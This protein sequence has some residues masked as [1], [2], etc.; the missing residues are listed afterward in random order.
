MSDKRR[1]RSSSL[2]RG[3]VPTPPIQRGRSHSFSSLESL[4]FGQSRREDTVR[5]HTP[6][7]L[8]DHRKFKIQGWSRSESLD[9]TGAKQL[10]SAFYDLSNY[11]KAHKKALER[12]LVA[13]AG[14]VDRTKH[15]LAAYRGHIQGAT[16]TPQ[17]M[18]EHLNQGRRSE[19]A[20]RWSGRFDRESQS[21]LLFRDGEQ[22]GSFL[23]GESA[24]M[25]KP[26]R[27]RRLEREVFVRRWD[28]LK[29]RAKS[30][31]FVRDDFGNFTRRYAY[32]IDTADFLQQMR[33]GGMVGEG[34]HFR[35]RATTTPGEKPKFG[36]LAVSEMELLGQLQ[37][38]HGEGRRRF[39]ELYQATHPDKRQALDQVIGDPAKEEYGRTLLSDT[40]TVDDKTGLFLHQYWGNQNSQRGFS[41]T[42]TGRGI[43]GNYGEGFGFPRDDQER[44]KIKIDL[45]RVPK[46][47]EGEAPMLFNYDA[48]VMGSDRITPPGQLSFNDRRGHR[49]TPYSR[50]Q[51]DSSTG[52]NREVF[53]R[54]LRKSF[55]VDWNVR[56]KPLDRL[57]GT[58]Y[59]DQVERV[60]PLTTTPPVVRE[61]RPPARHTKQRRPGR[62]YWRRWK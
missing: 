11:R 53:L 51:F 7:P 24:F 36:Q 10:R 6:A 26:G 25:R 41:L 60:Q 43:V 61:E 32:R 14:D 45:A 18:I 52:K 31:E 28:G 21:T 34:R 59:A 2:R 15:A 54:S 58:R 8:F 49:T 27:S 44:R 35:E 29:G 48:S 39:D 19:D 23:H 50:E 9:E 13:S 40:H 30:Q 3:D 22:M 37:P 55:V 1:P 17:R 62:S 42:S 12:E 38:G 56:M 33:R 5:R 4:G 47:R 57:P 20:P 16:V 46:R